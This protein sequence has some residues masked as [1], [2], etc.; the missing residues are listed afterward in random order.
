MATQVPMPSGPTSQHMLPSSQS[1]MPLYALPST[2][3]GSPIAPAFGSTGLQ[4]VALCDSP[5]SLAH[6]MHFS[7][8]MQS[9]ANRSHSNDRPP[10]PSLIVMKPEGGKPPSSSGSSPPVSPPSP[11]SAPP[12]PPPP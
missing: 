1:S 7:P 6:G 11:V 10:P 9:C 3:H 8:A 2:V 12:E 5:P 4:R